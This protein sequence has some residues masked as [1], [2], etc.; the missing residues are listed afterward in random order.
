VA[1]EHTL[2]ASNKSQP[3]LSSLK[4][5]YMSARVWNAHTH[6]FDSCSAEWVFFVHC[7]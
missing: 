2:T 3:Q 4:V 6:L 1:Q 7:V 5:A